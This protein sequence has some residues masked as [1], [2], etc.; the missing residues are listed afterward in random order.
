MVGG[1]RVQ[2]SF[3]GQ[4]KLFRKKTLEKGPNFQI[5]NTEGRKQKLVRK[6]WLKR[7]GSEIFTYRRDKAILEGGV[8]GMGAKIWDKGKT[9]GGPSSGI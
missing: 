5:G 4:W 2:A 9:G 8:I 6:K 3:P 1:L 7:D